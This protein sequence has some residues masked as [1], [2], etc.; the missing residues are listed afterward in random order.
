M[1]HL[2]EEK[3]NNY[4]L[5]YKIIEAAETSQIMNTYSR[6]DSLWTDLEGSEISYTPASGS[7][8]VIYEYWFMR[9]QYDSGAINIRCKLVY[10]DDDGSSWSAWGNNTNTVFGSIMP[11]VQIRSLTN[12]RLC[13]NSWG[14]TPKKLKVQGNV[15][16][17]SAVSL[18]HK[19]ETFYDSSG[20]TGDRYYKPFVTCYSVRN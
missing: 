16:T 5:N 11:E 12:L 9:T 2:F 15:F 3:N 17:S 14:N 4:L 8:Y 13:L 19:L 6:D 10:S 20:L 7:D 1:S 18:L